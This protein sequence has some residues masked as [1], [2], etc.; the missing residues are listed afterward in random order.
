M[1][2][3]ED[4]T[5]GGSLSAGG[6]GADGAV[7]AANDHV[8]EILEEMIEMKKTL[9]RTV[10]DHGHALSGWVGVVVNVLKCP[11]V[12]SEHNVLLCPYAS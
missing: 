4:G 10:V 3:I 6:A 12:K 11:N 9:T 5:V 2:A 7:A 1:L 8:E